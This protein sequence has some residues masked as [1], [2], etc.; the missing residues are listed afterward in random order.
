M[1][2]FLELPLVLQTINF[3]VLIAIVVLPIS[4]LI[5]LR[6][7]NMSARSKGLWA[8]IIILFPIVGPISYFIVRPNDAKEND[9]R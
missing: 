3:L 8:L 6:K 2:S 4:G 5:S 1:E 9:N 7:R